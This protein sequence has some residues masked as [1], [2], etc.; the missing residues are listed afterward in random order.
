MG[1]CCLC[2]EGRGEMLLLLS[3]VVS[4]LALAR[5][6]CQVEPNPENVVST[7]LEGSWIP[8]SS[9]NSWL[10]PTISAEL[11][12]KEFKFYKNE[13]VP[14][15]EGVCN[16]L[17][18]FL[19]GELTVVDIE[20]ETEVASFILTTIEGNPHVIRYSSQ[21][22][23][24]DSFNVMLARAEDPQNDILF[25]GDDHNTEGFLAWKRQID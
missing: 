18:V 24:L 4:L 17:T 22:D 9:M 20:G 1:S 13:S 21:Y 23:I 3:L 7:Q 8:D 12:I 10:S 5:P 19:E 14:F 2:S 16:S 11:D 25:T 6:Q 15:P